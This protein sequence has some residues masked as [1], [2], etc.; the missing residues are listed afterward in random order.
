M[1]SIKGLLP[2]PHQRLSASS[3]LSLLAT[4]EL[5]GQRN[6]F[7][8]NNTASGMRQ[9]V[10]ICT[11]GFIFMIGCVVLLARLEVRYIDDD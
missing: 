1:A 5:H 2:Y 8:G 6:H 10:G 9:D 4:F 11:L 3:E 7:S